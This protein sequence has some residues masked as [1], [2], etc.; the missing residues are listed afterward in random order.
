[1]TKELLKPVW[2]FNSIKMFIYIDNRLVQKLINPLT[3][4]SKRFQTKRT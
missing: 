4:Y 2:E 1:M 3:N